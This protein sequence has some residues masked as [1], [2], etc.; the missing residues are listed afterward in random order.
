M[1]NNDYIVVG[2][3][4]TTHGIKGWL[5]IISYTHPLENIFKYDLYIKK[6]ERL[7]QVK[8]VKS[9]FIKKKLVMQIKSIEDIND[10]EIYKDTDI[11]T[12]KNYFQK[13]KRVNII[14][15]I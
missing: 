14:G 10:A 15:M 1:S 8:I 4:I 11:Y 13:L 5:S 9:K 6:S 12:K 3:I 2:K 7:E